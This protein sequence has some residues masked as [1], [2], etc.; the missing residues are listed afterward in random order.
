MIA[1]NLQDLAHKVRMTVDLASNR[2]AL[3]P[4][5]YTNKQYHHDGY[6]VR[7]MDTLDIWSFANVNDVV[8]FLRMRL[9]GQSC[10]PNV[11]TLSLY[12]E[13]STS[14]DCYSLWQR[15]V[16]T[17]KYEYVG[18]TYSSHFDALYQNRL[19]DGSLYSKLDLSP[20]VDPNDL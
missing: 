4:K 3:D 14:I 10:Y 19:D 11:R 12:S 1:Q 2:L 18:M 8:A 6:L 7:A 16:H 20:I 17:G 5:P 13:R 15:N 9:Y